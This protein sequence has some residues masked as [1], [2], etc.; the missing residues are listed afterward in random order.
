MVDAVIRNL[1]IVGEAA[2]NI[3]EQVRD[4]HA[5]IPW[6][7]MIGLRNIAIHEYFGIDSNI[8]WQIARRNLP[9]TKPLIREALENVTGNN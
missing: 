9:E 3:P 1:E 7:R 5:N 6:S 4:R 2:R 8:I